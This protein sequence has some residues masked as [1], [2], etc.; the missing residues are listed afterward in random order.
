MGRVL[1]VVG[2]EVGW[3][4]GGAGR[5]WWRH[6]IA[7]TVHLAASLIA[8]WQQQFVV[9]AVLVIPVIAVAA[10]ARGWSDSYRRWL[11]DP[12]GRYRTARGLAA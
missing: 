11:A 12:L 7:A 10:W 5:L 3:W 2:R 4:V 8:W 6:R 9:F 1:A